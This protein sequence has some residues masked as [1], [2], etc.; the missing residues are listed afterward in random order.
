MSNPPRNRT[1]P[2]VLICFGLFLAQIAIYWRS[3][4][5]KPASDD[6]PVVHEILRGNALGPTIFFR[7]SMSS[8]HYRPFKSLAIWA[9]A[10]ISDVHRVFWIRVVHF[11]AMAGYLAVLGLWLSRLKLSPLACT[12]AVMVMLFH[13]VLPQALSS[14]D[15]VDGIGSCTFLWLGAWLVLVFRNRISIALPLA[16]LCFALSA[17]W[18]EYSFAIVPLAT[19]T[20]FCFSPT[21]RWRKAIIMGAGLSAVFVAILILR[22][23]A[24]PKGYGEIHG[25]DYLALNPIQWIE[26]FAVIAT[27]L[28]FFGDS[29]WVYVHQSPIVLA[30]VAACMA[31]AVAAIAGGVICRLRQLEPSDPIGDAASP[32]SSTRLWLLFLAGSFIAASFPENVIFHESE[33]Y[34][35]PLLLPLALLCGISAE[36]WLR[37]ATTWRFVAAGIAM[38][39]L[40]SSLVTIYIK[41]E[42]LRDVGQRAEDQARQIIALLPPDAHN[43]KVCVV[44]DGKELPPRRT[45]AVY[46]MGDEVLLVHAMA[47]DWFVPERHLILGSYLLDDPEFHPQD[48]DVLLKWNYAKKQFERTNP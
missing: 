46:R 7:E 5:V 6:F 30:M 33:M 43:L 41:V 13:P 24:M 26:N 39:A 19:W 11:I 44:F 22:Q 9:F 45:Y 47:L 40:I 15:G 23:Y 2:L 17:G 32:A 3:F 20:I 18:K 48:W 8:M 35:T 42:G 4:G 21:H 38:L 25:A 27:G 12:I 31:I 1:L 29:I 10:Q 34:L 36:G 14:I 28:I 16:I 37:R